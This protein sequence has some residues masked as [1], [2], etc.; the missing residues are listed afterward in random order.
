MEN[1]NVV[2]YFATITVGD[3]CHQ[4]GE[5]HEVDRWHID[6]TKNYGLK[7]KIGEND[8][9]EAYYHIYPCTIRKEVYRLELVEAESCDG[10]N[11]DGKIGYDRDERESDW[12]D[13]WP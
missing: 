11:R 3:D 9:A 5:V 2:K 8:F 6:Y 10:G 13:R 4:V 1:E 12:R 7:L